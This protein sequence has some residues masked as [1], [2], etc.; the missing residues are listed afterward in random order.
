MLSRSMFTPP[1]TV[2]SADRAGSALPVLE[3]QRNQPDIPMP[4]HALGG[5]KDQIWERF[6]M[7]CGLRIADCG[8]RNRGRRSVVGELGA[9]LSAPTGRNSIAQGSALGSESENESRACTARSPTQALHSCVLKSCILNFPHGRLHP[10]ETLRGHVPNLRHPSN[11]ITLTSHAAGDK[12]A[13]PAVTPYPISQCPIRL[14]PT[15]S[16]ASSPASER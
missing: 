11:R 4:F 12:W 3:R 1:S 9:S 6:N 7:D 2:A 5:D 10:R 14:A 15:G 16:A 13:R 8:L